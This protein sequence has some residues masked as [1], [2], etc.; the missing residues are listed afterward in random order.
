M[1]YNFLIDAAGKIYEGRHARNY[2]TGELHDGED[3]A[4]NVARGAHA[5]GYN[6]GSL[7]IVLLGTFDT[8]QPT[9]AARTSLEK[10]LA[11][12]AERHGINP[13]TA[14][15]YTNPDLGNS[16]VL[17]HISGHRDVNATDCPGA[18]FYPTFPAL[19]TAV[20]SRISAT[21]GPADTTPP[22]VDTFTSLATNPTGSSSIDVGLVFTEPVTG[23]APGDFSVGGTSSGWSVT[24]LKGVGSAYTVTVHSNNPTPGSIDLDLAA[25]AVT[26]GGSHTGP[27]STASATATFADDA[28]APTVGMTVTPNAP[29]TTKTLLNVAVTF[30]E[31][32][33]GLVASDIKLGGTS[34]AAGNWVVDP[35]VGSGANYGFT[36]EAV[37]APDGTL[38]IAIP[39]GVAKDPAGNTNTA[40]AVYSVSIDRTAPKTNAPAEV[41]RSGATMTTSLP[42]RVTW[43][44]TD[45]ASGSGIATYDVARSIDGAAFGT[46][47]TGLTGTSLTQSQGSGHS[48]RYEVRAHDRAGN[49]GAWTAGSTFKPSLLEQTSTSIVYHG[50]WSSVTSTSYSGGSSR[51]ASAAGAYASLTT[52]SRGFAILTSRDTSRGAMQVYVDGL[53]KATIDLYAPSFQAEYLAYVCSFTSV[54]THSI[55]IVVVGTAGRPRVYLDAFL[56]MR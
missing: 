14:S 50:T 18:L 32:V 10:L 3:L 48:Y 24:G 1:G 43:T 33:D 23:L 41:F 37:S 54:A 25:N 51:Y 4:G 7:G 52:S 16:A 49:I 38:T 11:W 5:K 8:V 13:T 46:I 26:D 36:V 21:L 22:A 44:A 40:S 2:A 56:I 53:L 39:A 17:N 31:P 34:N 12:A 27:P 15:T 6:S 20:Q 55:K 42:V 47:A 30:S 9:A 29:A 45:Y 35:V 28:T 19:R